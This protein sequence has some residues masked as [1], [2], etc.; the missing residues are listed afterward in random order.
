MKGWIARIPQQHAGA[1][2]KLRLTPGIEVMSHGEAI[3]LRGSSP[4]LLHSH[5]VC[6]LPDVTRF[7]LGAHDALTPIDRFVPHERLPHGTWLGLQQWLL[8]RQPAPAF[9]G[10]SRQRVA[11]MLER[12]RHQDAQQQGNVLVT[13]FDRFADYCESA[14]KVRLKAWRFAVSDR[15]RALVCGTPLPPL[16]GD[17]YMEREAVAIPLG[18]TVSPPIDV[19]LLAKHLN[20]E[21]GGIAIVHPDGCANVIP[22]EHLLPATRSAVRATRALTSLTDG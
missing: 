20:V 15:D 18:W 2:G 17:H 8:V 5:A 3:W 7:Q 4:D 6:T 19:K 21:P 13:A 14:S 16:L 12:A 10:E 22:N 9:A 1:L 11:M